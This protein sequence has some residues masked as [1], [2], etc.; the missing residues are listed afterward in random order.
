M[1]QD[2]AIG[3]IMVSLLVINLLVL[4]KMGPIRLMEQLAAML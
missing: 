4:Q 3:F 1:Q 2:I